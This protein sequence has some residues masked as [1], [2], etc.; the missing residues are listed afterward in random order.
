[1]GQYHKYS[2]SST[3][4]R[5][6]YRNHKHYWCWELTD[7]WVLLVSKPEMTYL[8]YKG[9]CYIN[10]NLTLNLEKFCQR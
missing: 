9:P 4:V 7:V 2:D 8:K 10:T 3:K 5:K 1:M 6:M